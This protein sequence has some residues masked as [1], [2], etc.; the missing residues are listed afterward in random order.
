MLQRPS[1]EQLLQHPFVSHC[2]TADP[3]SEGAAGD[4][5]YD[6]SGGSETARLELDEIVHVIRTYYQDLWKEQ[7][8]QGVSPSIPNFHRAKVR[9][10]AE[11]LGV[12]EELA[13]LRFAQLVRDLKQ[14]AIRFWADE[15]MPHEE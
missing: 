5:E 4:D 12:S 13:R 11:Q 3:N 7:A 2:S 9:R 15:D 6:E 10:L 8:A 14:D 1:A